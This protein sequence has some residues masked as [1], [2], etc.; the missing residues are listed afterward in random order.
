MEGIKDRV[1]IVTGSGRGIGQG[2]ALALAE[3]G[4]HIVC[5]DLDEGPVAETVNLIQRLGGT[6]AAFAGSVTDPGLG[7]K[8]ANFAVEQFGGLHI[9]VTA[10]GFIW[11]GMMH[12][13]T[14]E[15]WQSIIDV[16][17]TGTFRVTRDALKVMREHAKAEQEAGEGAPAR[18]IVTISSLSGF[19]NLGQANYSAAKAGIAG[20]TRTIALEGAMFNILANSVAFGLIDTRMTRP[21]ETQDE[22]VG[23]AIQGIPQTARDEAVKLIPLKRAAR[24]EEAVG[25]IMFLCSELSS[26]TTGALL[27]VNGGVHMT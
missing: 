7:D 12:R 2:V 10:A 8:L 16:H 14:D 23:Q 13:M 25:P 6:A 27:E 24:V 4:A 11:D 15:Q 22:K 5:N 9:V 17:L 19:G 18:H 20:L 1:A 26:Y 3:A 21:Q